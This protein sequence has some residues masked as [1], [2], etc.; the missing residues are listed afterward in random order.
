SA[1]V[2]PAGAP[3]TVNFFVNGSATPIPATYVSGTGIAA[4]SGYLHGLGASVT[5]YS[6]RAAFTSANTANFTSSEATNAS[7]LLVGK[8]NAVCSITGYSGI[9]DAASHGATGSCKD[10]NGVAMS[11]LNLG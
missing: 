11:G 7:A 2:S 5:A 10:I 4:V 8:A 1:T 6:V 9:Y 3:G